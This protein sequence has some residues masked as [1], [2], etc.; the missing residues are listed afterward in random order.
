MKKIIFKKLLKEILFFF[1]ISSLALTLI[2]WVIQA[3]N[4]L[5]IVS[6]DGHSF[7]VYFSYTLL[8]IPR[9]FNKIL[10][11]AFFFSIFYIIS[12]YEDKNQLL[13]YWTHGI[14]KKEFLGAIIKFSFL[15][16]IL[17]FVLS[18]FLVPFSQDK[19][20][21]FIRN[22]N[23]D[24]FPSLIK[25]KRFIDTVENLTIYVESKDDKGL[26]KNIVLKDKID[27]NNSQIILA[28]TGKILLQD[29]RKYLL[30]YDGKIINSS[31]IKDSSIFKFK[32]TQ[33]DL[34]K[35]NTKTTTYPKIQELKTTQLIYCTQLLKKGSTYTKL[36]QMNCEKSFLDN[37]IQELFKRIYLPVYIPLIALMASFLIL[38]SK[39]SFNYAAFK[40]YIFSAGVFFLVV[41]EISLKFAGNNML[42]N[43]F[44]L[45]TP[46]ISFLIM[47]RV[48]NYKLNT[49][50]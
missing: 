12:N 13:I 42:H 19:A 41:S 24:F 9:V 35:Y 5:D 48:F 31:K 44:F 32:E 39:S 46:I 50:R 28:K 36:D 49:E 26:I 37:I 29:S 33:F 14:K 34:N 18:V 6:E 21:S 16:L 8:T 40:I 45:S 30:L 7:R 27:P 23:L 20:R 1:L 11:F 25:P 2:I 17:H 38:K 47:Y 15:F 22:S 43:I 4:Y 10:P 3:V